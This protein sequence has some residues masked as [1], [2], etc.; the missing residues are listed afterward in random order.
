MH[1]C[2]H[3]GKTI[4]LNATLTEGNVSR[5]DAEARRARF[6][7][8]SVSASQREM[9]FGVPRKRMHHAEGKTMRTEQSLSHTDA[10]TP[11]TR[12][13]S[14]L[15]A[16]ASSREIFPGPGFERFGARRGCE[17]QGRNGIVFL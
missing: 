3:S 14:L 2:G 9:Y 16:L 4:P 11:S 15:R 10:G 17:K 7:F 6:L 5:R 13:L 8:L 12:I 1:C